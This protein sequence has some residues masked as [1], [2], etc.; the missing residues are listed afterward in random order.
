MKRG[1]RMICCHRGR[2]ALCTSTDLVC[3]VNNRTTQLTNPSLRK[4][5]GERDRDATW[6]LGSLSPARGRCP[7][8]RVHSQK[9]RNPYDLKRRQIPK[10]PMFTVGAFV[11]IDG[12]ASTGR[13][14]RAPLTECRARATRAVSRTPATA[15]G[16][17]GGGGGVE[18]FA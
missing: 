4:R 13:V 7:Q 6:A 15:W 12:K 8:L 16:G 1:C 11:L 17:V 10:P 14:P 2:R 3:F 9:S 18:G 5:E